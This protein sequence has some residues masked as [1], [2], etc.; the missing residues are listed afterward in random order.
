MNRI[1]TTTQTN[2]ALAVQQTIARLTKVMRRSSSLSSAALP[3]RTAPSDERNRLGPIA[4]RG[5]CG[6]PAG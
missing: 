6:A 4:R 5:Q 3:D 1:A 2:K